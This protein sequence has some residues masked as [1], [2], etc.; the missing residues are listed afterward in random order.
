MRSI[1]TAGNRPLQF[2]LALGL[3]VGIAPPHT[4][5]YPRQ[6][7]IDALHYAFRLTLRDDTD[8]IAGEAT[9][10]VRSTEAGLSGLTLDLSSAAMGKGMTVTQVT[11]AGASLQFTHEADRLR[12]MFASPARSGERCQSE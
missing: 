5:T 8:E 11:S 4:D 10:D 1:L 2:A 12:I 6:P 9:V 3:G 7:G